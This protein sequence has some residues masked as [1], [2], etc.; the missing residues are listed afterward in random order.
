MSKNSILK[1]F[2][3][4]K[5]SVKLFIEKDIEFETCWSI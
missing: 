5:M 3:K 2:D 1:S 4:I